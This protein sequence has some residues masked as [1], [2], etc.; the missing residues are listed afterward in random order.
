[1]S[2]DK[3]PYNAA[4]AALGILAASFGARGATIDVL[5]SDKGGL[6]TIRIEGHIELEDKEE[7]ERKTAGIEKAVVL[8]SSPGGNM[9]AGID[10]GTKI[11][12]R[13]FQTVV[14]GTCASS[15]ALMWLGGGPRVV[16]PGSR[17]GFH[18]PGVLV[19]AELVDSSTASARMGAYLST[20]GMSDDAV[21]YITQSSI[22]DIKWL[23][24]TDA[25][26][27]GID[28]NFLDSLT[29]ENVSET[30]AIPKSGISA[31]NNSRSPGTWNGVDLDSMSSRLALN[32]NNAYQHGGM[33]GAAEILE[34]CFGTAIVGSHQDRALYCMAL[35]NL[36]ARYDAASAAAF[37]I[38]R[39]E[40]HD[41]ESINLRARGMTFLYNMSGDDILIA[42]RLAEEA[43][44]KIH[45]LEL[46]EDIKPTD[47]SV[48]ALAHLSTTGQRH[49]KQP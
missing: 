49:E 30:T 2:I 23:T 24:P 14:D 12:E 46:K 3:L 34:S 28:A 32:F 18:A 4:F 11:H 45:R 13:G 48:G 21:G 41:E 26:T 10:I 17:V 38:P 19:G 39:H 42:E 6:P 1:M 29:A 5:P 15:C 8:L 43:V 35:D 20:V 25:K 36:T 40:L 33:I 31:G 44:K 47:I 37:P 16:T 22:H 9:K 7:F 27:V